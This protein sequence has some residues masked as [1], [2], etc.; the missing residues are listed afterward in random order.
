MLH[1]I[2]ELVLGGLAL[3]IYDGRDPRRHP[4]WPRR[5][6]RIAT[7]SGLGGGLIWC[8]FADLLPRP[9]WWVWL[10]LFVIAILTCYGEAYA[11]NGRRGLAYA[12][13][14]MLAALVICLIQ[15]GF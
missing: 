1:F 8:V 12:V 10:I 14:A 6:Q 2:G 5:S 13:M 9:Q 11:D 7:F 3:A 15:R 4:A